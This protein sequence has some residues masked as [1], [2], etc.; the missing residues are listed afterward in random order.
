MQIKDLD[1]LQPLVSGI[2]LAEGPDGSRVPH[3]N[4]FL[5]TGQRTVL[6]DAGIGEQR[7]RAIDA[8]LPIDTLIISHSHPDH[9]L[10][11]HVLTDR[12]L[13]LPVETP[14]SVEDMHLLGQR[15]A[16]DPQDADYWT[17]AVADRLGIR[18]MR[19][20]DGRF[21]HGDTLDL[22]GLQLQAIHAPGHLDDHYCF[23]ET[24]TGTLFSIDIDF[25]GF[26]PWYG[27]PEGNIERFVKSVQVLR[28][29]PFNRVCSS[30]K[31]P[32]AKS[33]AQTV[34]ERYLKAFER[35]REQLYDLCRQKMTVDEIAKVSPYYRNRMPDSTLQR[36][37]E[38]QMIRKNLDLLLRDNRIVEEDGCFRWA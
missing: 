13:L 37:F 16:T 19:S 9:I 38:T 6:I 32:V 1:F 31:A 29:L 35:Q 34:F 28:D 30:H 17:H 10:A 27:N 18:P 14:S 33:E 22:G 23:L 3:S 11:W 15:F 36:M 21:G 8:R 26:G 12:E 20:P 7:I 4:G 24:V 5:L 2:W 25:S